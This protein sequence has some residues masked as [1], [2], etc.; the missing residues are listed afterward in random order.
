MSQNMSQFMGSSDLQTSTPN[1]ELIVLSASYESF[2]KFSFLN[3][4]SCHVKINNSDPIFFRASQGFDAD[5]KDY[6]IGSFII[7]EGG[8]TFNFV[9]ELS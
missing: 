7:V 2:R 8:I 3:D 6:L 4:Q 1:Q 9:A 5:K